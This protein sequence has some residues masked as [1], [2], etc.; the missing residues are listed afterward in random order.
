M[1]FACIRANNTTQDLEQSTV[2]A[3]RQKMDDIS[4]GSDSDYAKYWINWF[5]ET[6]GNEYYC[7]IDEEYILDRFNL[8]GLNVEVQQYYAE[9][10]DMITD[11]WVLI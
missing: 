1:S 10:L 3:K 11:N 7:E 2:A 6:K 4:S 8:T 5:L 9:A